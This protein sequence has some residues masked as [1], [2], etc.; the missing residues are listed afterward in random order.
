MVQISALE[1]GEAEA[2]VPNVEINECSYVCKEDGD[3]GTVQ[4]WAMYRTS[5]RTSRDSVSGSRQEKNLNLCGYENR[6]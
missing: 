1:K 3:A 5:G 6:S 4:R 2:G